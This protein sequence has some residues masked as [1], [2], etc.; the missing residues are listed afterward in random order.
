MLTTS[1]Q[2]L[3]AYHT[4]ARHLLLARSHAQV[5]ESAWLLHA[6][7]TAAQY[8]NRRKEANALFTEALEAARQNG[9]KNLEH[10]VLHHWGRSRAEEGL[11]DQAEQ[12]FRQALAIRVAL[13]LPRQESTRKALAHLAELRSEQASSHDCAASGG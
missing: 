10:F 9:W 6:L 7:A 8:L 1:R 12:C 13:N 5:E 4:G 11:F 3:E 2:E